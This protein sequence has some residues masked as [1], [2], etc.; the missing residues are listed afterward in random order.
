MNP[1]VRKYLILREIV[2]ILGL[3]EFLGLGCGIFFLATK[4]YQSSVAFFV[5]MGVSYYTSTHLW[6]RVME[7]MLRIERERR[8]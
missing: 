2:I 8:K 3:L 6:Y 5:M 1:L 4:D 7:L